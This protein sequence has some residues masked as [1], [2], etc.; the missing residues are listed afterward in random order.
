MVG[1]NKCR[2]DSK[3]IVGCTLVI[4]VAIAIVGFLIFGFL[5][6]LDEPVCHDEISLMN[7]GSIEGIYGDEADSIKEWLCT[8]NVVVSSYTHTTTMFFKTKAC[9]IFEVCGQCAIKRE[10]CR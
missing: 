8:K 7:V 4:L 9:G 10:V 2:F 1:E 6:T 5:D 3:L